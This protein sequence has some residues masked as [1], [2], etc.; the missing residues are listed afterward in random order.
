MTTIELRGV[1]VFVKKRPLLQ[2]VSFLVGPGDVLW[3]KGPNGS[4]KSTVLK[5]MAGLQR[6]REGTVMVDGQP[7]PPG[8]FLT[9]AGVIINAPVFIG[10]LSGFANLQLLAA[11]RHVI[12]DDT[13]RQWM[14][15]LGLDPA[16]RMR[17]RQYSTGMNQKLA[18]AQA[19]MESPVVLLLDE[20][21]NGLDKAAKA[22]VVTILAEMRQARPDVTMV[23]VSH[24]DE[25]APLVTRRLVIDGMQVVTDGSER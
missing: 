11:I 17:V 9:N 7:L 22:L 8:R 20:P 4:G 15:R 2:D 16:E 18:I 21:L 10:T 23:I 24:E 12:D 25:V 5:M 1:S 6:P 14:S 19:V 3:L 13:V